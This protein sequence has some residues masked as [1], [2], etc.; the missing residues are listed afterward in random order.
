MEKI[1]YLMCFLVLFYSCSKRI[2]KEDYSP[3]IVCDTP[4]VSS[5]VVIPIQ[6]ADDI[7][8]DS[9]KKE[10][11]K[12]QDKFQLLVSDTLKY[13]F[14]LEDV[15]TEGNEGTAYY[16]NDSVKKIEFSIGTSM[17]IYDLLYLFG[18]ENIKVE[19][20]RYNIY[21]NIQL[22]KTFSY[23]MDLTGIPLE[24]VDSNRI[25]IFQK[26]KDVVPFVLK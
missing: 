1:Y 13:Q 21:E 24:K 3:I 22:L 25:D 9:I 11:L 17:W 26:I 19:E 12:L 6:K 15:G 18:N 23:T 10:I 4:V 16:L 5:Q 14:S 2:V 7:N 8:L 20:H